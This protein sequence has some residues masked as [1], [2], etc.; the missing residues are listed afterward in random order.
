MSRKTSFF[1]HMCYFQ[2]KY[3]KSRWLFYYSI[4]HIQCLFITFY[5]ALVSVMRFYPSVAQHEHVCGVCM[6]VEMNVEWYNKCKDYVMSRE[7]LL[8]KCLLFLYLFEHRLCKIINV[9]IFS[10]C[11]IHTD[12]SLHMIILTDFYP[13]NVPSLD[14]PRLECSYFM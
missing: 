12:L 7:T 5:S 8:R 6:W 1:L 10:L 4:I 2:Q 3:N 11:G 13:L 14:F 9:Q